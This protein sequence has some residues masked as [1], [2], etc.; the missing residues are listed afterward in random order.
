M[1]APENRNGSRYKLLIL[2]ITLALAAAVSIWLFP[3]WR[4]S[5]NESWSEWQ[6][7]ITFF[8]IV[9][10][11]TALVVIILW[12]L[13]TRHLAPEGFEQ[14]K[15]FILLLAEILGGATLL[16]SLLSTW[17]S[18]NKTQHDI[19]DQQ[20]QLE[21]NRA[22]SDANLKVAQETLADARKRQTAER[23]AKAVEQL[24]SKDLQIRIGAIY[25]FEQIAVDAKE[26]YHWPIMQVLSAY[27]RE[28]APWQGNSR[29]TRPAQQIPTDI[30]AAMIVIGRRNVYTADEENKDRRINLRNADLR[31]LIL[32]GGARFQG[33]N[34]EGT[35]FD[36]AKLRGAH[37]DYALLKNASFR[38]TDLYEATLAEVDFEGACLEN[39]DLQK[40]TGYRWESIGVAAAVDKANLPAEI[41]EAMLA[42]PEYR[43]MPCSNR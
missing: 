39:A 27:V 5:L 28:L 35:Q 30:E 31:G 26:E 6:E 38:R 1:S 16:V 4:A 11:L 2:L 8:A 25:A 33:I 36:E 43:A 21:Q 12:R 29:N 40:T 19:K 23:F 7:Y 37:F 20:V 10:A 9:L 32:K 41:K 22:L 15:D 3:T 17:Q 13:L 42:D 34:F 18:I 14:K 24:G